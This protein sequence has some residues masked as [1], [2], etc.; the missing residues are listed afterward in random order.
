MGKFLEIILM[1][2]VL[3]LEFI[4]L[5]PY[6]EVAIGLAQ[7][8]IMAF[9]SIFLALGGLLLIKFLLYLLFPLKE[10][11]DEDADSTRAATTN[12]DDAR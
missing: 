7:N 10:I 9:L 1:V 5:E 6:L 12:N 2:I 3:I 11:R 8:I 4:F